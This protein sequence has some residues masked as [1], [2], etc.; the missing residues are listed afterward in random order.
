M[1]RG[2]EVGHIFK[3]GTAY[4]EAFGAT[5]TDASGQEAPI[6]MGC[7]GI[8][9]GRLLAAAVEQ[10]HD[11]KGIVW[12]AAIAPYRVH[13]CGLNIDNPEVGPQAETLYRDLVAAGVETLFDDRVESAGVKFNDADLLGLPL[14]VTISPRTLGQGS[15]EVKAR[16]EKETV[17][18]PLGDAVPLVRKRVQEALV[19]TSP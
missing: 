15:V 6:M 11:P 13:L 17:L 4:S 8:G 1:Q 2:I 18:V 14:R 9:A 5:F 10:N 16:T 19:G 7:Y 12:P 3:L